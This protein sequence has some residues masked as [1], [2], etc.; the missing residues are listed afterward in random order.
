LA[1]SLTQERIRTL[2]KKLKRKISLNI[3]D[4]KDD[5]ENPVGTQVVIEIPV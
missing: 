4:L 5:N 1:T 3:Q 2:N